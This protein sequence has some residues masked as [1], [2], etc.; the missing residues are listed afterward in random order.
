M[1]RS[2]ALLLAALALPATL[3][4]TAAAQPGQTIVDLGHAVRGYRYD[5]VAYY[6]NTLGQTVSVGKDPAQCGTCPNVHLRYDLVAPGD[7]LPLRFDLFLDPETDHGVELQLPVMVRLSDTTHQVTYTLRIDGSPQRSVR[8][9]QDRIAVSAASD[10]MVEGRLELTNILDS[11][12]KLDCAGAPPG[13]RFKKL[14][15]K[16]KARKDATLEF[17]CKPETLL[18]HRS[19]T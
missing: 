19:L 12:I 3:A 11:T 2:A 5:Y 18:E 17:R 7:S 8:P 1:T 15:L 14:P 10:S 16:V 4:R 13:L 6:R 9:K